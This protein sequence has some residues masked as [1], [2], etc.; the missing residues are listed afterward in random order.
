MKNEKKTKQNKTYQ[1][2]T[3]NTKQKACNYI[4]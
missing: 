4:I 2:N 3:K 1:K